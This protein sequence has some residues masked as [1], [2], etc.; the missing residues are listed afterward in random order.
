MTRRGDNIVLIGMPGAGKSTVGI[1]LAKRLGM[2]FIDTDI[3]IQ[4]EENRTLQEIVDTCG[5]AELRRIEERVLLGLPHSG[6]I[7]ATGGSVV[8]G[9]AGMQSLKANGIVVFLDV[10][11]RALVD[12]VGDFTSRGLAKPPDQTFEE[13]YNE[14]KPL[15]LRYADHTIRSDSLSLENTVTRIVRIVAGD[16]SFCS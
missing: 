2:R 1:V 9:D 12:R 15:Y 8:Y 5:Y 10:G 16:N 7:V 14:R 4:T 6:H 13:L 11:F 3:V